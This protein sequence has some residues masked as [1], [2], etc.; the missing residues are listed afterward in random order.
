MA[1]EQPCAG[2]GSL[3][4]WPRCKAFDPQESLN[5]GQHIHT[6][7]SGVFAVS[8]LGNKNDFIGMTPLNGNG[9]CVDVVLGSWTESF[10][11]MILENGPASGESRFSWTLRHHDPRHYHLF[12]LDC[13]IKLTPISFL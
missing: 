11:S 13:P 5:L 1:T 2:L 8:T 9:F 10:V 7:V 6:N 3:H 12:F 4:P